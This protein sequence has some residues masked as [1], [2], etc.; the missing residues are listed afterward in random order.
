MSPRASPPHLPGFAARLLEP[1][2]MPH[3]ML[4]L[5]SSSSLPQ[6][7]ASSS[8]SSTAKRKSPASNPPG[9]RYRSARPGHV[10][11]ASWQST[12]DSAGVA[13]PRNAEHAQHS[14]PQRAEHAHRSTPDRAEHAQRS[15]S[16][17]AEHQETA[18][19]ADT[20]AQHKSD[21]SVHAAVA[22]LAG[23]PSTPASDQPLHKLGSYRISDFELDEDDSTAADAIAAT[24]SAT[25][26]GAAHVAGHSNGDTESR[27]PPTQS[28]QTASHVHNR[29][30]AD[31]VKVCSTSLHNSAKQVD[32]VCFHVQLSCT[33]LHDSYTGN[34]QPLQP[35]L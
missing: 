13:Q 31:G 2:D 22:V 15:S 30:K 6:N 16:S 25:G 12:S 11:D 17:T 28:L 4:D 1:D 14:S 21:E 24:S 10:T 3:D 9:T 35:A 34:L 8:M 23:K 19:S 5:H 20:S 29:R 33:N 7:Q 26:E 27:P 32:A 18:S